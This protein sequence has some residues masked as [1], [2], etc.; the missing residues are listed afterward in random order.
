MKDCFP[1]T[2]KEE[3]VSTLLNNS[4]I[5]WEISELLIDPSN[6]VSWLA[7]AQEWVLRI[8]SYRG[9]LGVKKTRQVWIRF[10]EFRVDSGAVNP[11]SGI[12]RNKTIKQIQE[13][14]RKLFALYCGSGD[15][16]IPVPGWMMSRRDIADIV[17]E[18]LRAV[19]LLSINFDK[20]I[21]IPSLN[22][23]TNL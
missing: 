11:R 21:R 2:P 1:I 3:I 16:L 22:Q 4:L 6:P 9:W 23:L 8:V 20:P 12:G 18:L 19:A 10:V 5:T 17:P 14:L 13:V 7:L 15:W